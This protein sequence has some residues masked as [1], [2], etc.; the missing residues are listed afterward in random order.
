LA[1]DS[2]LIQSEPRRPAG[3]TIDAQGRRIY[4]CGVLLAAALV[5]A[6]YWPALHSPYRLDDFAWLSLQNTIRNGHTVLWALFSPQAQGTIRPL[7]ERVWFLLASS[8]FGLNP[9]PLHAL[10]LGTQIGNVVLVADTGRRLL[11]SRQAAAVAALLWV[12]NDSLVSPIVWA[13]AFNEVFY[14]FCYLAAFNAFLRWLASGKSASEK[15]VWLIA[16]VAALA[17]CLGAL[18]LGATFPAIALAYVLLVHPDQWRDQ[19]RKVFPSAA[20]VLVY[21]VLH[22]AAAPLPHEGPYKLSSG[23]GLAA[24]LWSYWVNVLGPEEYRRIH[25]TPLAIARLGTAILTLG[26]L[27]WLG[28]SLRHKKWKTPLFCL[29]WFLIPLAP[30][31]PLLQHFTPYYLFLPSI[32]LA[33]LAGQ[34]LVQPGSWRKHSLGLVCVALYFFAQVPST[35]FVRDWNRD[36]A[37]ETSAHLLHLSGAVREIRQLQPQGP[38][39]LTGLDMEQ[40][41]W[42]F[43]YGQLRKQG[44]SDLH[45]MPAAQTHDLYIPPKEW[46]S[47]PDFQLSEAETS[48]LL[49]E[50]GG[51]VYDVAKSS[52]VEVPFP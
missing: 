39:F 47:T 4:A 28:T 22:F 26:I 11:G 42:G 50:G 33:W 7:G 32:G 43:C 23:S 41:W 52:P 25:P 44:F 5:V 21:V 31:L 40:F 16:H 24:N 27:C 10:A 46:C 3:G 45:V 9:W 49:R 17:L 48:R 6:L 2:Q 34:A 29:L 19:W 15:K 36:R 20:L 37:N 14:T 18:E 1:G 51:K 12:V 8:L 13:S 30:T 38:V 35:I